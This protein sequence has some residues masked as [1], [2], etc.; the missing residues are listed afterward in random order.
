MLSLILAA[1]VITS[2]PVDGLSKSIAFAKASEYARGQGEL[3]DSQRR[4]YVR[5]RLSWN[6]GEISPA[7]AE[8]LDRMVDRACKPFDA[9]ERV[10][11]KAAPA[12]IPKAP[13]VV[14]TR[15]PT[16]SPQGPEREEFRG[17]VVGD[18]DPTL[19]IEDE[20]DRRRSR[21]LPI[22][23]PTVRYESPPPPVRYETPS[24]TMYFL[25]Q[26]FYQ[27]AP[28]CASGQCPR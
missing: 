10:V 7:D 25:P 18:T 20:T 11:V 28:S 4:E 24:P 21:P 26:R 3:S 5:T 23:R 15:P 19:P 17:G 22:S 16:P 2:E 12:P 1:S 14:K 6:L 13:V 9:P 8:W 27:A